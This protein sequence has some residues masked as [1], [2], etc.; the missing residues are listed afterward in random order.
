MGRVFDTVML[1]E[2]EYGLSHQIRVRIFRP[3]SYTKK[4]TQQRRAGIHQLAKPPASPAATGF[5]GTAMAP[6]EVSE[7]IIVLLVNRAGQSTGTEVLDDQGRRVVKIQ[8]VELNPC[9]GGMFE[10]SVK[11]FLQ[12]TVVQAAAAIDP[13]EIDP[14]LVIADSGIK[15]VLD[16]FANNGIGEVNLVIAELV[17][18]GNFGFNQILGL[19]DK[20]PFHGPGSFCV[21]PF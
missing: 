4:G 1:V 6:P 20:V 21:F 2:S 16:G 10:M 15:R 13:A 14:H 12:I 11:Q 7:I 19:G 8:L 5:V 17:P 3:D 9:R 18:L